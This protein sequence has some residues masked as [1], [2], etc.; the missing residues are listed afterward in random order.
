VRR[1]F[2][3][4]LIGLGWLVLIAAV[5]GAPKTATDGG[6]FAAV[7]ELVLVGAVGVGILTGGY[8]LRR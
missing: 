5:V 2:G 6:V 8:A 7:L 4:G 3:W 1:A